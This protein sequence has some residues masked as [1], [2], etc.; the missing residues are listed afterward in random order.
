MVNYRRLTA[1][2]NFNIF[3]IYII[4]IIQKKQQLLSLVM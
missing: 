1:M 4:D 3:L 2:V